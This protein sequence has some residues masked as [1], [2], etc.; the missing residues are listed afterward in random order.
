MNYVLFLMSKGRIWNLPFANFNYFFCCF[1]KMK[2]KLIL[3]CTALVLCRSVSSSKVCYNNNKWENV[4]IRSYRLVFFNFL[5][6][7]FSI[8]LFL[9]IG[10]YMGGFWRF[11]CLSFGKFLIDNFSNAGTQDPVGALLGLGH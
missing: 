10:V 3:S 7:F 4:F 6:T 9:I 11:F 8:I 5:L 2:L 1:L